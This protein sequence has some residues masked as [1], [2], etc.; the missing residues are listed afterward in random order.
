MKRF[1]L[2]TTAAAHTH[3]R[4]SFHRRPKPLYTEK[5]KVSCSGFP[6]KSPPMQ[7]SCS[8]YTA[9]CK[10]S[11]Q[12][13]SITHTWTTTHCGTQRRNR[14]DLETTTAA[15]VAHRRYLP[16]P[17]AATSH[18][19]RQGFVL[20]LSP[21]IT[22]HANCMQPLHCDLQAESQQTQRITHTWTTT[23]CRTQRMKRFDLETTAAAHTGGSF[24]RRPKPL[25]TEKH[26]VSCS[27]FPPKSPPMQNSCSHYTAICKQRV[28]KRNQWR[29]HEQPPIA[30]HR[31]GTDSTLKR[32]QPHPLHTGG[33]FHRQPKPLHME[34]HE[35]SCSGFPPKSQPMQHSCSHYTAIPGKAS[36][37]QPSWPPISQHPIYFESSP[38]LLMVMWCKLAHHHLLSIV[39]HF[40]WLC[41]VN[42]HATIHWV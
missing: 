13:Q 31:G 22:T 17:A 16:S 39:S 27:G 41:D 3:K 1:D 14:F 25:Y 8:H 21:Q 7:N 28:N 2:E 10:Q 6:P 4:Y 24:H 42:S 38:T 19:K 34:K 5:H 18:G 26:K 29:T 23:H 40:S 35:V 30:E 32:P 11:Q 36:P 15:P 37:S 9:I 33:T 12:T 20:R